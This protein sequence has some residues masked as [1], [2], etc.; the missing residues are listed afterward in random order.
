MFDII[1]IGGGPGGYAAAIRASQLG[2]TVALVESDRI[3]GTCVNRGCIPSKIWL[4]GA[5]LL[6]QIK[7][8]DAFGIDV[9]VNGTNLKTVCERTAGV[10]GD[11]RMGM[12]GI[13]GSNRVKLI[14]GRA[15]VKTPRMIDVDGTAYDAKKF[16]VATGS[17]L[18]LSDIPG[19]ESVAITTNQIFEMETLPESVLILGGGPIETEM[20]TLLTR[21]GCRVAIATE[22]ARILP[23]EDRDTSQRV[24]QVLRA[25]GIEII[26]GCKFVSIAKDGRNSICRLSEPDDRTVEAEAILIGKRRPN[27]AHMGLEAVGVEIDENGSIRIDER[28]QTNISGIYAIGDATGGWMLSHAASAMGIVAAE[29]AMGKAAVFNADRIPRG[30]W[31]SPEVGTVG[32]SEEAAEASGYDIEVGD[33][34]YSINGLA[35]AQDQ[36]S[37]A[38]KIISDSRYGRILGVHVVGARATEIIGE[39]VLAM[40][41]EATVKEFSRSLRVHPT[42]SETMVEAARDAADWAL[43]VPANR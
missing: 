6:H 16:I 17:R 9:T 42:F 12:E 25:E 8:A 27:T 18:T 22:D 11:I 29:N 31:T 33:F 4:S 34:P 7:K 26:S 3:G 21:F 2:G 13:L 36:L 28:L 23:E 38:V 19:A 10:T 24:G 1:V 39:A 14:K 35:L 30:I 41:L 37:G 32:L 43:Y 15:V 5:E 40:E 20:A